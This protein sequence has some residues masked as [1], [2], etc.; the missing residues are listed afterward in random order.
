LTQS[1]ALARA[2]T[3]PPNAVPGP[4]TRRPQVLHGLDASGRTLHCGDISVPLDTV[5]SYSADGRSEKDLSTA[6]ATIAV[7]SAVG[8]LMVV[9]VLDIGWRSRFLFEGAL[10]GALALCAGAELFSSQRQTLFTFT[11]RLVDG[12]TATFVTADVAQ[13]R[14]VTTALDLAIR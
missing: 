10:F 1:K 12:R 4:I 5:A 2:Q 7:F 14:C 13:A 8:A 6:F 11:L 3:T 9:G